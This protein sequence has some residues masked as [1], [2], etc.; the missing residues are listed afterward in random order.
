MDRPAGI[1]QIRKACN[2]I[3]VEL[4]G[5]HPAVPALGEKETQDEIYKSLFQL[6][7]EVEMIKKRIA[8]LEKKDDSIEL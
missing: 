7:K 1:N 4:M 3:S 8:K 5:I 6:T 2:N